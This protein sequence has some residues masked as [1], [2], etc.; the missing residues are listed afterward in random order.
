M[1]PTALV[2]ETGGTASCG[3]KGIS[4][5]GGPGQRAPGATDICCVCCGA[6]FVVPGAEAGLAP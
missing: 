5:P 1:G 2:E 4:H 6:S 3:A